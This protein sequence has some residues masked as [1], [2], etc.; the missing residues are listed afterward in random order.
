MSLESEAV[1]LAAAFE[2]LFDADDKYS[3][4]CKYRSCFDDYKTKVV[5][6]ALQ[7]HTGIKLDEGDNQGKD[8]QWQLGRKWIQELYDLRSAVVHG[9]DLSARQWGWHPFEHLLIGAYVYPLAVKTLLEK[10]GHYTLSNTDRIAW[11]LILF[12]PVMTGVNPSV[13]EAISLIGKRLCPMPCGNLI[14][15]ILQR[16]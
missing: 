9:A 3:L 11:Q 10:E 1:L 4:T 14:Q 6:D 13:K 7:E 15:G 8:L 5:S 2:V 12:S 16:C